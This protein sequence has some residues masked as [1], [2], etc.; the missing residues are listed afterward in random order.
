MTIPGYAQ[1]GGK[2][3]ET[4]VLR[5]ILRFLG[6]VAPHTSEPYSEAMLLGLGGGLGGGYFS[7]EFTSYDLPILI[8]G[9]RHSWENSQKF[10]QTIG[11]RLSLPMGIRETSSGKAGAG[12]LRE[13]LAEGRPA[14]AWV[15]Q[16]RLPYYFLPEWMEKCVVHVVGVCG[17]DDASG[18]VEID[19]RAPV[20][21]TVEREEFAA[22]RAAITSNR[23]RLAV[24]GTPT[25]EVDLK[26]AVGEAIQS[27]CHTLTEPPIRN[28]GLPAIAK[29][30]DL[31]ANRKDKKGWPRVFPP[32]PSLYAGLTAT[33]HGVETSGTGGG[34][35]RPMYADFLDEASALLDRPALKDVAQ[36]YRELGTMWSAFAIAALPDSI[37]PFR[38]ARELMARK[39]ELF[40]SRGAEALAE[41]AQI[42][43]QLDAVQVEIRETFPLSPAETEDLLAD[44][45]GRLWQV[46]A[47]ECEAV[48][49]L[50]A[51]VS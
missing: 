14:I 47:A 8:V 37:E 5:N 22:A 50:L 20:P 40:E 10:L 2:H 33:F 35:F 36:Q 23:H 28:F 11:E 43:E 31:M 38:R 41:L 4:A 12:Q 26:T 13:A 24:V 7:W 45:S 3:A 51:T 18:A 30:A 21:W 44:V 1:L 29:W 9:T 19:D 25:E 46:H 48:V 42:Y 49:A 17:L 27:C 39:N 6:V 32:G 16:A 15:D 34:A